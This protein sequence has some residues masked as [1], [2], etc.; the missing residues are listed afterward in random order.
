[1]AAPVIATPYPSFANVFTSYHKQYAEA[2][3]SSSQLDSPMRPDV[4]LDEEGGLI[5]S[6]I[7]SL[8]EMCV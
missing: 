7:G 4:I 8:E 6:L 1:M 3:P 2:G 5:T